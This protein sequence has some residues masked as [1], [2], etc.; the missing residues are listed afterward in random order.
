MKKQIAEVI[1]NYMTKYQ[2]CIGNEHI[3]SIA[4]I[5]VRK[6]KQKKERAK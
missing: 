1:R 6:L 2:C 5:I 4:E 3:K